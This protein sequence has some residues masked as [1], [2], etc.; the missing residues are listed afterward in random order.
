[1]KAQIEKQIA[2][3][4]EEQFRVKEFLNKN[5]FNCTTA[6]WILAVE[7]RTKLKEHIKTLKL[8]LE[9]L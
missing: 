7:Y 6:P 4:T 9:D 1:M 2:L 5:D 8:N 3:L